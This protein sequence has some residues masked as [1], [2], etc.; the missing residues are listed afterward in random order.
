MAAQTEKF[1]PYHTW[2]GIPPEDQPPSHYR[3]LGLTDFESDKATI[4]RAAEQVIDHVRALQSGPRAASSRRVLQELAA[5]RSCLLDPRRK[6][7]YDLSLRVKRGIQRLPHRTERTP[8]AGSTDAP[9]RLR[10]TERPEHVTPST[11]PVLSGVS[12]RR[13]KKRTRELISFTLLLGALVAL[14]IIAAV[15]LGR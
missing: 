3:L 1:D 5:A 13:A 7:A 6:E 8:N 11:R 14:T 2:L 15:L 10:A 9:P 12:R 4:A